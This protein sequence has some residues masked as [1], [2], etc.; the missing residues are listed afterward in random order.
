MMPEPVHVQAAP[1]A[2]QPQVAAV[3]EN[4]APKRQSALMQ[5]ILKK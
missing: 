3:A 2:S 1:V 4:A 5:K